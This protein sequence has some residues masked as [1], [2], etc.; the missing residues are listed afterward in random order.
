MSLFRLGQ[1]RSGQV[2]SLNTNTRGSQTGLPLGPV[3]NPGHPLLGKPPSPRPP[4][5]SPPSAAP[6]GVARAGVCA[7]APPPPPAAPVWG[8]Y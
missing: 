1:V 5:A 8:C 3:H 2:L 6:H 4:P 7:G